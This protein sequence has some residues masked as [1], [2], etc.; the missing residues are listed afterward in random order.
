METY[1]SKWT[2]IRY[3]S[4]KKDIG[5]ASA[6]AAHELLLRKGIPHIITYTTPSPMLPRERA[7]SSGVWGQREAGRADAI[8]QGDLC[9]LRKQRQSML[10]IQTLSKIA[11]V[12][13]LSRQREKSVVGVGRFTLTSFPTG[14]MD[15]SPTCL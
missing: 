7:A 9:A 8:P 11:V 6:N 5:L 4:I 12:E 1:I 15:M 14:K 10:G 3:L 2:D 13:G